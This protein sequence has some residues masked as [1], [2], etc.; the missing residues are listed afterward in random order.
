MKSVENYANLIADEV[1]FFI[2]PMAYNALSEIGY[3]KENLAKTYSMLYSSCK[4]HK[5]L[6]CI[7]TLS[8]DNLITFLMLII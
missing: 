6:V 4:T 3:N 8:F 2:S 7:D 5:K 1:Y